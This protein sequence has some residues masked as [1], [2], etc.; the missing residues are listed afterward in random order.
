M[1]I[2]VQLFAA[3]RDAAGNAVVELKVPTGA[4]VSTLRQQLVDEYTA[5][6]PLQDT[7]LVAVNNEYASDETALHASDEVACFPPV[8]GG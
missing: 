5:L 7:L 1:K 3:A 8:S 4:N 2:R 6:K